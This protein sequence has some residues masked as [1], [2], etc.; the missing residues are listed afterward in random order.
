MTREPEDDEAQ[1]LVCL[2]PSGCCNPD[3]LSF[4]EMIEVDATVPSCPVNGRPSFTNI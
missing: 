2:E 1:S 4:E 3:D